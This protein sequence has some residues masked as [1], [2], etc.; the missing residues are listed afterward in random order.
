MPPYDFIDL[1]IQRGLRAQL[2]S[3]NLLTGELLVELDF[4]PDAEPAELIYGDV[5]PEIP[6]VPSTLDALTASISGTLR[7]L[8][9]LPLDGLIDDARTT[10]QSLSAVVGSQDTTETVAGL[11]RAVADLERLLGRLDQETGPLLAEARTTLA[12]AD[13]LIGE[14][15]QLRFQLDTMLRELSGAARSIRLFADYL[16][17]HPEA[18]IQGKSGQ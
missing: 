1:M 15:S 9:A 16:E 7:R 4:H 3:G 11:N 12:T 17:R 10:L 14:D 2:E 8:A 18:L 6:T 5:Y 13:E